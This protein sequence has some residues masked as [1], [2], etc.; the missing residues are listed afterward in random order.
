MHLPAPWGRCCARHCL[1]H[2]A[3]QDAR[4]VGLGESACCG[5]LIRNLDGLAQHFRL[6]AVDLLGTGMSGAGRPGLGRDLRNFNAV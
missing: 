5:C 3:C 4:R 1:H 6:H 2:H